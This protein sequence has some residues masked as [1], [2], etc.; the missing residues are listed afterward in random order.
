MELARLVYMQTEE[1]PKSETFGLRMQLRRSAVSVAS[2][3]ADGHGR[4]TDSELR[5][6]LSAAR[7]SLYELE[8]QAELACGLGYLAH[9]AEDRLLDVATDVAKLINGLLGVLEPEEP[10]KKPLTS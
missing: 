1:F 9:E 7:G 6:S 5:K 8:T 10:R 2:H 4:L 3:I